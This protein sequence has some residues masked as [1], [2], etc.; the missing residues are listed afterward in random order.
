MMRKTESSSRLSPLRP[1]AIAS[2]AERVDWTLT[3]GDHML[4]P[5]AN[6]THYREV[7]ESAV[8]VIYASLLLANI[9]DPASIL[10]FASGSGRVTRWLRALYP[11]SEIDVSDIRLDSLQFL[12]AQFKT[13]YWLSDSDSSKTMSPRKY[14]M[15][16]CGSLLTHLS[17][18]DC[19]ITLKKMASW[20][21]PGGL[22]VVTT[23]G[24][25]MIDNMRSKRNSYMDEGRDDSFLEQY[26]TKG[27]AYVPYHGQS[28][29]VSACSRSWLM[30]ALSSLDVRIVTFSEYAWDQHQDVV[31]FQVLPT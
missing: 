18:D 19:R 14:D 13:K 25:R 15:I 10:D 21:N 28:Y 1:S 17:E 11:D 26:F 6:L 5:D 27:Y 29:G 22:A 24:L 3:P 16:W 9:N 7:G 20:L 30:Q 8:R 12:E 4:S 2:A 23:H 31:A